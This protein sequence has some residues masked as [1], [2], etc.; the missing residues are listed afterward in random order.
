MANGGFK[1]FFNWAYAKQLGLDYT[2]LSLDP[3]LHTFLGESRSVL[4][5]DIS[6]KQTWGSEAY[7]FSK[8]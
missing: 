5:D 7:Y 8:R 2:V 6:G 3:K 1:N 4:M